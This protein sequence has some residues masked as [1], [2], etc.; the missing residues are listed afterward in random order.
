MKRILFVFALMCLVLG[1]VFSQAHTGT[2][3]FNGHDYYRLS[4]GERVALIYGIT[5][6][7][8][9]VYFAA[10]WNG[11]EVVLRYMGERFIHTAT[12]G[13]IMAGIDRYYSRNNRSVE[14]FYAYLDAIQPFKVSHFQ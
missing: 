12:V 6:G 13:Q 7:Y 1:S 4:Q 3:G 10:E 9:S 14:L 8:D 2:L 11:N 5:L